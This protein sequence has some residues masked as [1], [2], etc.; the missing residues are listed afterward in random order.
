[1]GGGFLGYEKLFREFFHGR[2]VGK[3]H[4]KNPKL[5]QIYEQLYN[6]KYSGQ[7]ATIF[8]EEKTSSGGSSEFVRIEL[9]FCVARAV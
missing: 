1:M 4:V 6:V 9:I 3:I 5:Q 2:K 8:K 7:T